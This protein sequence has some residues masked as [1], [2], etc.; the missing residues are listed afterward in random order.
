MSHRLQFGALDL[1]DGGDDADGYTFDVLADGAD[2]GNAEAV[3]SVVMSMMAD[4]DRVRYDRAGNRQVSFRVQITGTDAT[5]LALGEAALSRETKR[6]NTLSWLPPDEFAAETVFDVVTSWLEFETDDRAELRNERVYRLALL[7]LP[8]ARSADL[9][10]IGALSV[11]G[12]L[13][14]AT[15]DNCDSATGWTATRSGAPYAA[16]TAWEAGAVG[17]VEL[18]QSVTAPETWTLTSPPDSVSF[19]TMPYLVLELRTLSTR[20]AD[21]G[22][23]AV[24][25]TGATVTL[26]IISRR[27]LGATINTYQEVTCLV[28]GGITLASVTVRHTSWAG[29]VWQGIVVRKISQTNMP[30]GTSARQLS[31]LIE[32]GGTE[33]TTASLQAYTSSGFLGTT[34]LHT[35]PFD[36]SGYTPDMRRWRSSGNT[37]ATNGDTRKISGSWEPMKPNPV[38]SRTPSHSLPRGGYVLAAAIK[39]DTVGVHNIDWAVKSVTSGVVIGET[40]GTKPWDFKV[41]HEMNFVPIAVDLSL[42][43]VRS[44]ALDIEVHMLNPSASVAL[45]VEEWWLFKVDEDCALSVVYTTEGNLWAD[46]P[47]IDNPEPTYWVGPNKAGA[48]HPGGNNLLAQG[49]HTFVPGQMLITTI[50]D[51]NDYVGANLTYHKR[52]SSHA[53]E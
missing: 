20:S 50:S 48:F 29:D 25:S 4:G 28:A 1:C 16:S 11:G 2:F 45:H 9:T 14:Q 42:P 3:T 23:T 37:V 47:D 27:N 5:S 26:P 19:A 46:S 12:S 24:T 34:F 44:N 51:R 43:V 33:R 21:L 18:D 35:M 8:F 17:A 31:R 52:W 53:P 49:S 30:P 15:I 39:S 7:C 22:V 41:A 38:V 13:S 10:T 32:V 40:N 36:G 6:G